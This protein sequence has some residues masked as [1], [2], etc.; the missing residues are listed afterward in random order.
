MDT[1]Y[2]S[3][4]AA[5]G[6]GNE[7]AEVADDGTRAARRGTLMLS[8][9]SK[10]ASKL[11]HAA[12]RAKK[13]VEERKRRA[14]FAIISSSAERWQWITDPVEAFVAARILKDNPDGSTE[15]EFGVGRAIKTVKKTELGPPIVRM[16]ELKNPVD[17]M[18]RMG[19]VNEATILHN[20]RMRFVEDQIY[21]NI[22]ESGTAARSRL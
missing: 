14:E 5:G 11:G 15:V 4:H 16:E 3:S 7:I 9:V 21:T 22:G 12:D 1:A 2:N 13:V 10:A 17:D 19:D 20:L 18:V 8:A 6:A